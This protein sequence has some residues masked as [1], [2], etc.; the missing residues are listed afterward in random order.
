M[1]SLNL[2]SFFSEV[3][4]AIHRRRGALGHAAFPAHQFPQLEVDDRSVSNTRRL[5]ELRKKS[6]IFSSWCGAWGVADGQVAGHVLLEN[7]Q[8]NAFTLRIDLAGA[9][10]VSVL[11]L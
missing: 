3:R 4:S 8:T 1:R 2:Y 6:G 11:I 7:T 5:H 9:L 10:S